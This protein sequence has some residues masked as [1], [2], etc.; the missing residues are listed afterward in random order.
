MIVIYI[1]NHSA[2]IFCRRRIHV[3]GTVYFKM[4]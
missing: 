4:R 2:A 1:H 3:F